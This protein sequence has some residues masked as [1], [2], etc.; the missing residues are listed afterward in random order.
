[1]DDIAYESNFTYENNKYKW[2]TAQV[3]G[4]LSLPN[5]VKI[6]KPFI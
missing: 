2:Q 1:M 5:I 3:T 4:Q 6:C